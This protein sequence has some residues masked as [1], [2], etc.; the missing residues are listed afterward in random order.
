MSDI[1]F[2]HHPIDIDNLGLN[3]LYLNYQAL[4]SLLLPFATRDFQYQ[5][6]D[7]KCLFLL[8]TIYFDSEN[9]DQQRYRILVSLQHQFVNNPLK[10]EPAS[11]Q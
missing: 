5:K 3:T 10:I 4:S 9:N 6:C 2:F 8:S 11:F 1:K 7:K